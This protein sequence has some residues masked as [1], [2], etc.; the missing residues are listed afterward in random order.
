MR[1]LLFLLVELGLVYGGAYLFYC[2]GEAAGLIA[3]TVLVGIG[4]GVAN[5]EGYLKAKEE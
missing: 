3:G 2:S 4:L 1:S 5:F